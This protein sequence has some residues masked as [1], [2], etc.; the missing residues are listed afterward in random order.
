MQSSRYNAIFSA[1]LTIVGAFWIL[2]ALLIWWEMAEHFLAYTFDARSQVLRLLEGALSIISG[3]SLMFR[4]VGWRVF[5]S[6][7]PL[8]EGFRNYA[9]L[10]VPPEIAS[11]PATFLSASIVV[12]ALLTLFACFG[13]FRVFEE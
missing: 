12:V 11:S 1:A 7:A 13:M 3:V 2:V 10:V 9:M 8:A 5:G 4:Q 6:F